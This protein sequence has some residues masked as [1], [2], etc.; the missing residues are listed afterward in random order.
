MEYIAVFL[1]AFVAEL[2]AAG[3]TIALTRGKVGVAVFCTALLTLLSTGVL[4]GIV[5]NHNLIAP[6]VTGEVV[7]TVIAM[8][9]AGKR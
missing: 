8:R 9:I 4:L 7:G 3:Y 5:D 6:S 1:G 2:C